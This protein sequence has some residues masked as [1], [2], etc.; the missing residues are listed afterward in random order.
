MANISFRTL[1]VHVTDDVAKQG[2][3][4][5]EMAAIHRNE[6]FWIGD[7]VRVAVSLT[8]DE[9]QRGDWRFAV[10]AKAIRLIHEA[11][12]ELP[13]WLPEGPV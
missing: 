13:G 4:T 2:E 6:G 12:R 10:K 11:L 3:F 8:Y 9:A 7:R 1:P 5:I